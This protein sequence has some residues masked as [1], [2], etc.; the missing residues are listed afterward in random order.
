[1]FSLWQ[2]HGCYQLRLGLNEPGSTWPPPIYLQA[3]PFSMLYKSLGP[4]PGHFQARLACSSVMLVTRLVTKR[5]MHYHGQ[6]ALRLH[7]S[8]SFSRFA[9]CIDHVQISMF[10]YRS[11][12]VRPRLLGPPLCPAVQNRPDC[13]AQR[14]LPGSGAAFRDLCSDT[15]E[16]CCKYS[17]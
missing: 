15:S 12:Q 2:R 3:G 13:N 1:M 11:L 9:L 10:L 16:N 4:G 8:V 7:N 6:V 17:L 5:F 14:C